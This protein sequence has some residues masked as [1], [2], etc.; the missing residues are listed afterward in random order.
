MP[1]ILRHNGIRVDIYPGDHVPPHVHVYG[2]G[3]QAV[4][5]IDGLKVRDVRE[6]RPA[7]VARARRLVAE[8]REMLLRAWR[9]W[10]GKG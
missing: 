8:H 3:G 10:N 7:D 9:E 6:M 1:T 4:I 5:S 2:G